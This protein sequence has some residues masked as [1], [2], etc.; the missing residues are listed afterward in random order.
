MAAKAKRADGKT[1]AFV[2]R[3]CAANNKLVQLYKKAKVIANKAELDKQITELKRLN[4]A[5][6]K[7]VLEG[8]P[9]TL[10]RG[11]YRVAKALGVATGRLPEPKKK[12]PKRKAP[13]RKAAKKKAT[14]PL[15]KK[16]NSAKRVASATRPPPKRKAVKKKAAKKRAAPKKKVASKNSRKKK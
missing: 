8:G 16:V 14:R 5:D 1:Q 9:L 10:M 11:R 4:E 3:E 12:A 7:A 13:K 6:C 2:R 15:K